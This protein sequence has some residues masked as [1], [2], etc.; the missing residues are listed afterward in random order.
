[1]FGVSFGYEDKSKPE[2][3]IV[4]GRAS[5]AETTTFID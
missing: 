2:N 3:Q 5:V 4:P 1:M